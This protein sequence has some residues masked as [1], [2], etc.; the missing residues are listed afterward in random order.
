MYPAM[1]PSK[2]LRLYYILIGLLVLGIGLYARLYPLFFLPSPQNAEKATVLVLSQLRTTIQKEINETFPQLSETERRLLAQRRFDN[3]LKEEGAQARTAIDRTAA[4]LEKQ[5]PPEDRKK[6]L[7]A[8]DSYYYYGLTKNILETGQIAQTVKGSK[9][10]NERTLAPQGN[11]EP[12]NLH[13]YLGL[14]TYRILKIFNPEISLMQAVGW[15]PLF[16]AALSGIVFLTVGFCSGWGVIS[17]SIG[18]LFFL[19]APIFVKRSS[20]N[21]YDNDPYNV[22][23]PL[24]VLGC[25]FAGF[26]HLAD[27]RK[28]GLLA[29]LCGGLFTLYAFFWQGWAYLLCIIA[30]SGAL[31]VLYTA[32]F[33]KQR[34]NAV[35][36]FWYF[37]LMGLSVLLGITLAFGV[38]E[39]FALLREGVSALRDFIR[40]QFS[41][42]PNA[43]LSVGE[44]KQSGLN[45]IVMLTGGHVFFVIALFGAAGAAVRLMKKNPGQPPGESIT[46][47]VFL[48]VALLFTFGAQRFVLLCLVPLGLFFTA[49]LESIIVSIRNKKWSR[50]AVTLIAVL[51][52]AVALTTTTRSLRG[53]F[54]PIFN[55]VW[56]TVLTRVK[57]ETPP[58]AIVNTWWPPGHF[59]KA[60]AERRVTFDGG[61]INTPQAYWMANVFLSTDEKKAV[62]ILRMLNNSANAGVEY[63]QAQGLS[64]SQTMAILWEVTALDQQAAE[65]FLN[66]RLARE[67]TEQLLEFTHAAPPPSYVL[68][69][70]ELVD[71]NLELSFIGNWD[72]AKAEAVRN[73]PQ[74]ARRVPKRGSSDYVQFLWDL[75]GGP[76]R[77]SEALAQVSSG[78]GALL[79]EENIAINLDA[80]TCLIRSRKFG[81]GIPKSLLYVRGNAVVEKVF[82]DAN[83]NFSV[84]LS[85]KEGS[86]YCLVMDT[87]LAKSLLVRMYFFEGKG[88]K[89]FQPLIE[90]S[91]LTGRTHMYVYQVKWMP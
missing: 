33:L 23:F 82:P 10:F 36:L 74:T 80:Q 20:Y 2:T 24:L 52:A 76:L 64:L 7:L 34:Q 11:W 6:Y 77:S 91:D 14:F 78:K 42:W 86:R 35:Q 27:R 67:Q 15:T 61:T 4:F 71:K 16:I 84:V 32:F 72:F 75:A 59:I 70:K 60:V 13:P 56:E 29:V 41:L 47:G 28:S 79:F 38:Q 40:P 85:G 73:D 19:L 44:L 69:Y 5:S 81:T 8:A 65:T 37:G 49:G 39:F 12:L 62:G 9:Y 58:E 22:L 21:W 17:S 83:L 43:Y 50:P 26:R 45:D 51:L 53:L 3:I 31:L 66:G 48:I 89:Y 1:N 63:L 57:K 88:L 87:P 30:F 18:A 25:L 68:I 55:P 46:L 90:E 54:D